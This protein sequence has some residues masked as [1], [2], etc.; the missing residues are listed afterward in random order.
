MLFIFYIRSPTQDIQFHENVVEV[1]RL[2]RHTETIKENHLRIYN[3]VFWFQC[4]ANIRKVAILTL[5]YVD[6]GI[7]V[8]SSLSIV[9]SLYTHQFRYHALSIY[10]LKLEI[11]SN[12]H[13]FI[14]L[15]SYKT[16]LRPQKE[17]I[18]Y[19][20]MG[21]YDEHD[22]NWM[23]CRLCCLL[24]STKLPHITHEPIFKSGTFGVKRHDKYNYV[25]TICLN[26]NIEVFYL[27]SSFI[28]IPT[29]Q[30]TFHIKYS[31]SCCKVCRLTSLL[32]TFDHIEENMR[33]NTSY[34]LWRVYWI[35]KLATATQ[36]CCQ[37]K[38]IRPVKI[39][40]SIHNN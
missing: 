4:I 16:T 39:Y 7:K 33:W 21:V 18:R 32:Y 8:V 19:N 2:C 15:W 36:I 10:W 22:A 37:N 35:P 27:T 12:L 3:G 9:L 1:L 20:K 6:V 25:H 34:L 13:M 38:I 23:W 26:D 30:D 40:I 24:S 5:K 29:Y 11:E 28:C 31:T 14:S 17:L